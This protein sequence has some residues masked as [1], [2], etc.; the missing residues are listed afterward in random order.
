V[1]RQGEIRTLDFGGAVFTVV[2]VSGDSFNATAAPLV[3]PI[4]QRGLPDLPPVLLQLHDADPYKGVIDIRELASSAG[5]KLSAE[6]SGSVIGETMSRIRRAV[7]AIV[8]D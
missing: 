4:V 3:A 2:I 5:G 8:E 7:V 6:P 1:I